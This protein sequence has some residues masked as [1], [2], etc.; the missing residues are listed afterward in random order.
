LPSSGEYI[1]LQTTGRRS[2]EPH[3][4]LVRFITVDGK[5]VVFPQNTGKQDWLANILSDP[6]V[7]VF[8]AGKRMTG[9]ART[10]WITGLNDPVLGIFTRKYGLGEVKKRYWGQRR[11]VEI[12]VL[13]E[14]EPQDFDELV[15]ADLEAAFDGVAE[16]YD[17][18]IIDNPMNLWLRNRSVY[19]LSRLFHGG[20]VVLEIGCGTGTETLEIAKLGVKVIACDIS[21]KMLAVLERKAAAEGL[22]D[23]VVPVHG[24]PGMLAPEL[25]RLGY[26]RVD[27]AYSTYG[28]VNTEPRLDGMF[29]ELHGLLRPGGLLVLGVWNKYCLYEMVGYSLRGKPS[30]AVAR[31]RNPVPVGKSR[32]CIASW[33]YSVGSLDRIASR[34]FELTKVYG[35]EMFLPPSNLTKYLPRGRA[36][37]AVKRV[38][39]EIEGTF[40]WNR[41]GDH[42]LAVYT[43]RE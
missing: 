10:R 23:L 18:H 21:S 35:V 19:H 16:N 14:S 1:R 37:G 33:A 8:G 41:L 36:L 4:V 34:F 29:R 32:F 28:A 2:R 31:F 25:R 43:R 26:D 9:T 24:H 15:Y 13:G 38:E 40:P 12:D 42:F 39:T 27:G 20:D 22:R 17:H 11:Y 7:T 30:M 6:S 5:I 3:D